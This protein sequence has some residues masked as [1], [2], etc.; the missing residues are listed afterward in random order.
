MEKGMISI[1]NLVE[2]FSNLL[3]FKDINKISIDEICRNTGLTKGAFYHHFD[4]K[5]E[6]ICYVF[7]EKLNIYMV[8]EIKLINNKY[9][10][11]PKIQIGKWIESIIN[12]VKD[13]PRYVIR[14][15]LSY[16]NAKIKSEKMENWST[17]TYQLFE[18][19]QSKELVRTDISAL[20]LQ[21][22]CNTFTYG[23]YSLSNS[24]FHE[25]LPQILVESFINSI[26]S[27]N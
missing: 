7:I 8:N 4:S 12:Y 17:M 23:L 3:V 16:G 14:Y 18:Y 2:N 19:W 25:N 11:K 10:D 20:Q 27:S 13:N 22:Y 26:L 6:F 21:S 24:V 5:E 1:N 15:T 9:P